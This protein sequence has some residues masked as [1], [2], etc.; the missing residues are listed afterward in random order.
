MHLCFYSRSVWNLWSVI[1]LSTNWWVCSCQFVTSNVWLYLS[2]FVSHSSQEVFC[3]SEGR[4]ARNNKSCRCWGEELS[5]IAGLGGMINMHLH[6]VLYICIYLYMTY[7]FNIYVYI[8]FVK[9]DI[10]VYTNYVN[11]YLICIELL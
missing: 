2:F 7:I 4:Q 8:T 9:L 1:I 5:R 3:E 10:Y 11:L 6:I